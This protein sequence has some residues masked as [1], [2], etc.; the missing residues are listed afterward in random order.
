[1]NDKNRYDN[2]FEKIKIFQ[3]AI[4][5]YKD[6]DKE[7]FNAMHKTKIGVFTGHILNNKYFVEG[8]FIP[9]YNIK[10]IEYE[11]KRTIYKKKLS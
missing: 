1:M 10:H 7:H 11:I 9:I 4:V 2:T 5:F 3:D 6:G 8:G